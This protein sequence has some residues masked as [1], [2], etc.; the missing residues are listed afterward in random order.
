VSKKNKKWSHTTKVCIYYDE[1]GVARPPARPVRM[2]I[3]R[4][5]VKVLGLPA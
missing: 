1:E 4:G 5:R 2:S 3:R